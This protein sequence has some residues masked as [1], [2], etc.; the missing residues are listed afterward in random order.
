MD[1]GQDFLDLFAADAYVYFPK[2]APARGTAEIRTLFADIFALFTSV[3]HEIPYFNHITHGD[4]VVVEGV[5]H[6]VLADGTAW[7][8]TET[9]GG[10]FC[11]VFKISESEQ[12]QCFALDRVGGRYPA[13]DPRELAADRGNKVADPEVDGRVRRIDLPLQCDAS[14]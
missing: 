4:F 3:V 14:G 13:G 9:L 2:H 6:G 5:T 11:N 8:T 10:R 7:R 12:F 1:A